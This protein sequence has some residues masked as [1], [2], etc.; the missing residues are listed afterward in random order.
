MSKIASMSRERS[1]AWLLCDLQC[2]LG[3]VLQDLLGQKIL[4]IT[5]GIIRGRCSINRINKPAF[6]KNGVREGNSY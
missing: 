4:P 2:M 6:K 1:V 5:P 3:T